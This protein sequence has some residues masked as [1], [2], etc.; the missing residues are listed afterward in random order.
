MFG[1]SAAEVRWLLISS[2]DSGSPGDG[3]FA[4]L[5][6]AALENFLARK[7]KKFWFHVRKKN[8]IQKKS[9]RT[10]RADICR[11]LQISA[12]ICRYLRRYLVTPA[13]WPQLRRA[14]NSRRFYWNGW[15][16]DSK[17]RYV[18]F[19]FYQKPS[20]RNRFRR[21]RTKLRLKVE[22]RY[23]SF[24]FLTKIFSEKSFQTL[25]D[26]IE[27]VGKNRFLSFLWIFL[28]L[29]IFLAKTFSEKSFQTLS[30]RI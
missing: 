18:S 21:F 20:L 19:L 13:D 26:R 1:A 15:R 25:S 23:V 8:R 22:S 4:S 24:L 30:D 10:I 11:Y 27:T 5:V 29:M 7:Q 9:W 12:G 16:T 17:L 2:H 6:G 14:P 3:T 28:L